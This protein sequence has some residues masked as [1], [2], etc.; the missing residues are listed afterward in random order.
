MKNVNLVKIGGILFFIGII[1]IIYSWIASYPISMP[2]IEENIF[3]KFDLTLWPGIILSSIGL[4]SLSYFGKNTL[5]K[6]MSA[7]FF[8]LILYLPAFF[9]SYIPLS[10]SG[11]ARGM[12][13]IFN[14]IG[15]NPHAIPYFEFP[16]YFSLNEIIHEILGVDE[17]GVALLSFILYG[18]L[19]GLFLYLFFSNLNKTQ[20]IQT[21]PYLLV[22]IYFIGMFSYL[23][24]QWVP[25]TLALVYFFLLLYISTYMLFD[26]VKIKWK[27]LFIILFVPLIFSHAFL[28]V[29][30]I[31]F[32]GFLTFK[33]RFLLPILMVIISIFVVVTI[34]L[35]VIHFQLYVV[36]FEQSIKGFGGD[37][38]R[39]VSNAFKPPS[40]IID[41]IISLANRITI[42]MIWVIAALGTALLFLKR[43]IHY[44]LLSLGI[45]G[46]VYLG[47]GFI[48]PVL[49]MRAT[50]IL[51]IPLTIG[52]M[53]FIIKWKKPTV[54]LIVIIL[55]L[56]VFG[57]MRTAYNF[58]QFQSDE[59]A[60][61]CDLLSTNIENFTS[62]QIALDQVNWG[63]LTSK[64]MYLKNLHSTDYAIRP[65]SRDFKFFTKSLTQKEYIFYN[66][67][68]GKEMLEFVM[69]KKQLYTVLYDFNLNNK[70]FD[71]GITTIINGLPRK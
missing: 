59:E 25:Q 9:F 16:S 62:T 3:Y 6:V 34:Y 13:L 50:Q 37:Y 29:I 63:Y 43:K 26:P 39:S 49:G 58:T 57:P 42:P 5:M 22:M 65:G 23:N 54:A 4:F 17:K 14:K 10:D 67:N 41:Q 64:N 45:V 1:C 20:E 53:Y 44:L 47:A 28:P 33:R 66:T 7:S 36:T 21:F 56:A 60:S 55:V 31:I 69:T 71:S 70:I 46:A 32:F 18:A 8:P 40:D 38:A 24:Y 2:S 27:F 12:F 61:A 51:F 35:T 15:I 19:I 11:N 48:Y 52:F 30:F 68:L